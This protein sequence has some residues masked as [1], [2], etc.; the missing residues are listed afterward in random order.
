MTEIMGQPGLSE[1]DEENRER[2]KTGARTPYWA[3]TSDKRKILENN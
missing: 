1:K 2:R 3:K